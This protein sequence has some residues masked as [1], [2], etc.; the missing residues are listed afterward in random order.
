MKKILIL[1]PAYNEEKNIGDVLDKMREHHIEDW[2]DLLVVNDGS[3]DATSKVVKEKG[4]L[5]IDHIFNLGYGSA[6]QGGYKYAVR[7]GYDYIVQIDADG[8]HDVRNI[9]KMIAALTQPGEGMD[10]KPDIVIG[11]RF[12]EESQS[13][14]VGTAKR[15]AIRFF[16]HLIR[17]VCHVEIT[18]PTSG[19][20]GLNKKAFSFYAGY[21]NFDCRYP[22]I[23]MIIQMLMK[24]FNIIEI[25]A[26]MHKR[27]G[28]KSMHSGLLRVI[29]Y[30]TLM[31]LSTMNAILRNYRK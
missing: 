23:N 5:V 8:Q 24:G 18:D 15:I 13:F 4:V 14:E 3:K 28:G 17:R 1:I 19:L 22:D 10:Q 16:S 12:L 30:M 27:H 25:P 7:M 31:A 11:S 2:A 6:L 9:K 20:Q 29:K 26:I 21:R